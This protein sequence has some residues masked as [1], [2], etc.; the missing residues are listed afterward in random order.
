MSERDE[1]IQHLGN[2][3]G[4]GKELITEDRLALIKVG[5]LADF[6]LAREAFLRDALERQRQRAEGFYAKLQKYGMKET[7]EVARLR[8]S[9]EKYGKHTAQCWRVQ[10]HGK[11]FQCACGF[12]AALQG[13]SDG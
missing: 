13:G 5:L 2:H 7:E 3:F 1:L 10:H 11:D 8:S 4:D 9:L 12:D 6:I